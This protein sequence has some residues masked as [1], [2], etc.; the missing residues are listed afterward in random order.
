MK[1]SVKK[2]IHML[3][4]LQAFFMTIYNAA[5][6]LF[7]LIAVFVIYLFKQVIGIFPEERINE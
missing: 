2:N 1:R 7:H 3:G 5:T 4:G 6:R